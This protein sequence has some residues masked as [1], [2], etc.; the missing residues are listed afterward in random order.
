M[1]ERLRSAER[2][3]PRCRLLTNSANSHGIAMSGRVV[4]WNPS[5]T[6]RDWSCF[7]SSA[8]L[9]IQMQLDHRPRTIKNARDIQSV[10]SESGIA[11]VAISLRYRN[12][13][14]QLDQPPVSLVELA[15]PL[16]WNFSMLLLLMVT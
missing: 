13:E 9:E 15:D 4:I 16:I 11:H 2:S 5:K 14:E 7:Q 12:T 6:I 3:A 8:L 1:L 10:G